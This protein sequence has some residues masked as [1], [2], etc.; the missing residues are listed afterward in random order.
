MLKIY[1]H[2]EFL[3]LSK[4][5]LREWTCKDRFPICG[6]FVLIISEAGNNTFF[7]SMEGG[8]SGYMKRGQLAVRTRNYD[9]TALYLY[10][11]PY[12][13]SKRKMV[14][15]EEHYATVLG[16]KGDWFYVTVTVA[17]GQSYSG[18]L[19]PNMQCHSFLTTCG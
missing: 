5:E 12:Y 16:K 11:E 8:I 3:T 13:E 14:S 19:P 2:S 18:W 15:N 17:K 1:P 6:A 4:K 9:N 7:V 10:E